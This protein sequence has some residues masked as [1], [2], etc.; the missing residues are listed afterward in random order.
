MFSK[1]CK[2]AL[3]ALL[4]IS[5]QSLEGKRTNLS[6]ITRNI[7]SPKAFTGKVLGTL[8]K[9]GI[10]RS[11]TGPNGGFDI[12]LQQ[13]K[14]TRISDVVLAIDGDDIFVR[15]PLGFRKCN[16]IEPC[17][18]HEDFATVRDDIRSVLDKTSV[19]DA[20]TKLQSEITILLK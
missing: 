2:Y 16:D 9:N 4:Y 11:Y 3:K 20:A 6:D 17:P 10:I 1:T 12:S 19:F 8:S 15:C 5:T 13:M 7:A 14:S 18:L